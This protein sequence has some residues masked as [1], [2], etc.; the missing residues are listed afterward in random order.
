MTFYASGSSDTD[1]RCNN[2]PHLAG[3]VLNILITLHMLFVK[4]LVQSASVWV[5]AIISHSVNEISSESSLI[6]TR[7][8]YAT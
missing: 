6:V 5:L 1:L 4:G 7:D 3:S 8:I 2:V